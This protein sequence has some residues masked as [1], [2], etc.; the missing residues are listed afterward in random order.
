VAAASRNGKEA[1]AQTAA[2]L[3]YSV[4]YY[5][6]MPHDDARCGPLSGVANSVESRGRREVGSVQ[7]LLKLM[8]K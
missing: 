2:Q 6:S 4:H 8:S 5:T 7:Q 1:A 3:K